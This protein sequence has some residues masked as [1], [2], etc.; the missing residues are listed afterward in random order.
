MGTTL[1]ACGVQPST[2]LAISPKVQGIQHRDLTPM[3]VEHMQELQD[4]TR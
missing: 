3:E 1:A 2:Q 4:Q